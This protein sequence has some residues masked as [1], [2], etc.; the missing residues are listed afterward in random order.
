MKYLSMLVVAL[1]MTTPAAAHVPEAC[2]DELQA[3]SEELL[4]IQQ[5]MREAT[6]EATKEF[7]KSSGLL[8][9][10][11][12]T[13]QIYSFQQQMAGATLPK[14]AEILMCFAEASEPG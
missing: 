11:G 10:R 12:L 13:V 7:L 4:P 2:Q 6:E 8:E 9:L 3:L 14:I 1:A 5:Y